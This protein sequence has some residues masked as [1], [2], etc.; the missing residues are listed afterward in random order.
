M[1]SPVVF[2]FIKNKIA[3]LIGSPIDS[4]WLIPGFTHLSFWIIN[5]TSVPYEELCGPALGTAAAS[6]VL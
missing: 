6:A 5:E 1:S 2:D 3:P 4:V